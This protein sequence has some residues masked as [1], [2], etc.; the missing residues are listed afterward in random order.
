MKTKKNVLNALAI[1]TTISL[2]AS[3][4]FAHSDHDHSTVSYKWAASDD[5]K[6]K[7]ERK[8]NAS[9]IDNLIGLSHFEQKKLA[10]YDINVGNKFNTLI[11]GNNYLIERT[12]AGMSISKVNGAEQVA[13]SD[14]VPI[15][16]INMV[17]KASM[18]HKSHTGHDHA[19][20]PYEWTFGVTTQNKI[21]RGMVQNDQ[22]AYVGLNKFEQ[23][24]LKEYDIKPGN[25]FQ[26][27]IAGHQFMIEKTT[28]GI[29]VL[30]HAEMGGV[31]MATS[32]DSSM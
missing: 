22:N 32:N 14:Q 2:T 6:A 1:A 27:T 20:L 12:S 5:F 25:T 23:S 11:D 3:A 28:A 26:T 19:N 4:A 13:Y 10:H 9:S 17:S 16:R 21:V 24:L 18:E 8:L 15:K 30:N 7:I 29:K 31:A